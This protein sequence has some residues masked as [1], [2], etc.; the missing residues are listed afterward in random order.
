MRLNSPSE[1]LD[2]EGQEMSSTA[3]MLA[4]CGVDF[5]AQI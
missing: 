3:N 2:V 1:A 5:T 4:A